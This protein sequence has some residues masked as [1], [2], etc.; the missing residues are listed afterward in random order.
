MQDQAYLRLAKVLSLVYSAGDI[1]AG[2]AHSNASIHRFRYSDG[3]VMFVFRMKKF[4]SDQLVVNFS[5]KTCSAEIVVERLREMGFHIG[6]MPMLL[7]PGDGNATMFFNLD[8]NHIDMISSFSPC[9]PPG[10]GVN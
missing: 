4:A 6:S 3:V 2:K 7:K 1:L 9:L 8:W 10:M 5:E